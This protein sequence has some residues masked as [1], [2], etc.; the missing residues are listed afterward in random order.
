MALLAL[1]GIPLGI[2]ADLAQPVLPA[3]GLLALCSALALG[4]ALPAGRAAYAPRIAAAALLG[5]AGL[6]LAQWLAGAPRGLLGGH[7]PALAAWQDEVLQTRP[8]PPWD[9]ARLRAALAQP[10][11]RPRPAPASSDEYLFNALLLDA[12]GDRAGAAAALAE[13]LRLA[14]QP[15]PDALLLL[16]ALRFWP[17]ARELLAE[18]KVAPEAAALL[19]ARSLPDPQARLAALEALLGEAPDAPLLGLA[20]LAQARIAAALPLGPTIA[21]AARI[22]AT[23]EAFSDEA[24]FAAFAE[25]F[26]DPLRA[27][28]LREGIEA[29][30][31]TR[32]LAA[33]RLAVTPLVPPPG[34]NS[35][36]ML[37]RIELP[38]P[39]QAVQIRQGEAWQPLPETPGDATPTLRMPRPFQPQELELRYL[40]REGQPSAPLS[41]AFDPVGILRRQAQRALQRQGPFALYQPGWTAPGQLNP[42]PIA[43]PFRA[44]LEAVEWRT[45]DEAAPRRVPVGV[46]DAALLEGDPPRILVEFAPPEE[47]RLLVLTPIYAD[48]EVGEPVPLQIR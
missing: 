21:N 38:E 40:D 8:P 35:L 11:A 15:R 13:S 28:R 27:L 45:D 44:G 43:G 29:L 9:A 19:E 24:R 25:T 20:A 14:P 30:D 31:W 42:L 39:A 7:M 23:V 48:G 12:R 10:G 33:R 47:A 1:V 37:L 34:Q 22:A 2:A 26:L 46:P 3:A 4:L 6:A 18:L 32:E 36:P 41:Y 17:Q 16:E 5:F